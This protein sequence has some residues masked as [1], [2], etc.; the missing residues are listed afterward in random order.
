MTPKTKKL[1]EFIVLPAWEGNNTKQQ[2]TRND[3]DWMH[4]NYASD[5][6]TFFSHFSKKHKIVNKTQ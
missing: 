1:L 3:K 5:V 2:K 6:F 4:I